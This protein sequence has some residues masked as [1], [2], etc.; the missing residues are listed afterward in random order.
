MN[1]ALKIAKVIIL[2]LLALIALSTEM[3]GQSYELKLEQRRR[4]N[5]IHVE[6][7]ARS[8]N[9]NAPKMGY[10]SLI[11]QYNTSFLKPAEV[12]QPSFTDTVNANINQLNPIDSIGSQFNTTNGYQSLNTR[13]YGDG[14]Y[15]LEVTLSQ[16]GNQGLAP[17]GSG[18]GS[19]IGKV[20]FDIIDNPTA[21]DLT[22]IEWSKS[23]LPGN[24]QLFD[25]DSTNIKSSAIWTDPG[26]FTVTGVTVLSP[27]QFGQVV[28]RDENY[29]VLTGAY[30]QGGYPIYFERSIS[31]ALYQ[32]PVDEDLA[33][34]F[35]YSLDNGGN[36]TNIG[37]V[38]ETDRFASVVGNQPEY[39]FGEIYNPSA[40]NSFTITTQKGQRIDQNNYRAPLRAIWAKNPNFTFRSE[41]AIVKV[42]LISGAGEL[43]IW[44]ETS[45]EDV[46]NERLVLGRLF[47][48]QLNGEYEYLKTPTSY[49]NATQLTVEAWLN[50]NS[51]QPAGS[52]T[53]IVVSSAG[54]EATPYLGSR[55]GAWM[56]YLKD[57][58]YPAF[59]AREI[60]ARGE[61]GFIGTVVAYERDFLSVASD[62]EP[63]TN[64]HAENWVHIAA[65]VDDNKLKLYVNG[66]IV[67]EINNTR[68]TDIRMMT[69]NHPIWIG[70][71][72]NTR[73]EADDY[74]H[75]GIKGVKV[76]RTALNQDEIRRNA[77][78]VV[79][80]T[81]I[82]G[83]ADI[84]KGLQ[85]YYTFEGSSFDNASDTQYQYGPELLDYYRN[86]LVSSLPL[87][88]R[89]DMPHIKITSPTE[90]V[91]VLNKPND[92]FPIRWIAY[93]IG[94]IAA[95]NTNDVTI[96]YSIDNGATWVIARNQD[97]Q[98]LGT[99]VPVDVELNRAS[100]EAY[101]NNDAL[102]NIRTINP[103]YRKA[104]L[105]VR[106]NDEYTQSSLNDTEG[107]FYI[108][109]YFSLKKTEGSILTVPATNSMNL[110]NNDALI[111]A[112]IRPYRFPSDEERY[113]PIIEKADSISN[114]THYSLR[115]LND[116]ALEF[117][118]TDASGNILS[119]FSDKNAP[120]IKPNSIE[121]DTAWTHVAVQLSKNST[122][123]SDVLFYIDGTPQT[124]DSLRNQFGSNLSINA[125]N[126]HPLYIGYK[127]TL[128][129]SD[130][131]TI[132]LEAI[133]T[134]TLILGGNINSG[135]PAG[136]TREAA[137][138]IYDNAGNDYELNAIFTKTDINNEYR[139][140]AEIDGNDIPTQTENIR[141]TGNIN[142]ADAIGSSY[143]TQTVVR[144]YN[145]E[146]HLL[147]LVFTKTATNTYNLEAFIGE[148]A[149]SQNVITFLSGG[150][151]LEPVTAIISAADLNSVVG[152]N[153]FDEN[154][155]KDINISLINLTNN[156]NES[157]AI[158]DAW[159]YFVRFNNDGT[160]A[161][162]Y[163]IRLNALD[164]N[165]ALGNL[166]FDEATPKNITV[167]IAEVG[168]E[169]NGVSQTAANDTYS[170]ISQDGRTSSTTLEFTEAPKGFIGEIREVRFWNGL[171]NNVSKGGAE[172]TE[173]TK[174]IQG[175]MNIY[176]ANLTPSFNANL[177]GA[178]SFNGGSFVRNGYHRAAA[179]S[180]NSAVLIKYFGDKVEYL[181]SE[182]YIK[183][184]E[185]TFRQ[186]VANS[187]ENLKVRWAGFNFN[188]LGFTPG[189]GNISPSLE[190]SIRGG[191]GNVIQ[192]YQYL[193]SQFWPGNSTNS[194][195]LPDSNL[196]RYKGT[197]S[198]VI[199][200]ARVNAG[201][202]DPDEN[203]DGTYND[204]GP[205]S[206]SLTNS[207]LRLTYNY[208]INSESKSNKAEG[209]LFTVT[210]ASNFTVRV[211]LEGYHNGNIL[212]SEM[213]NLGTSF[214]EGGLRISLYEDNSGTLGKLVGV[215]ESSQ[216]YD[217]RNPINRNRGN[218]RFANVNFIFTELND[219]D[220]WVLVEHPNHLPIMSRFAAP[221]IYEGDDR[222]TWP[223]ES[224]WDFQTWN[225]VSN[226]VL[227]A[228][229][230]NPYDSQSFTAFGDAVSLVSSPDFSTTGLIYNDGQQGTSTAPIAAM[231]GGDVDGSLQID[232]AD[233][234][235]VRLDDG[236]S[237]VRSDI[238]GDK[239]VNADD[240]TIT[241]RNFGHV[242]ST[243]N[244]NF[245]EEI[246]AERK[247]PLEIISELDPDLS[248]VFVNNAKIKSNKNIKYS[249]EKF[250]SQGIIYQ[251]NAQ[252]EL[253]GNF[254]NVH[255]YI[256]NLGTK[257]AL[258]N[259]TFAIKYDPSVLGFS[260]LIGADS[261]I[262]SDKPEKGY[263]NLRTAPRDDSD[264]RFNDVRS[265]E[266][267]YDAYANPGGE[268][269][270]YE[271]TFIGTLRFGIKD[272]NN[273]ISFDWHYSTSVH[274]TDG[275][276]VT[277]KGNFGV[278]P[279][280][281]LY[282]VDLIYP[283]G[284]ESFSPNSIANI[285]WTSNATN[286]DMK[287]QFSS[288]GG[289]TWYPVNEQQVLMAA[290]E[291]AWTVPNE[292]STR[293]LI[294]V[295]DAADNEELDRSRD[296]FSIL[297][298]FAQ[299]IRP[300]SADPLYSGGALAEITWFTQG[301]DKIYFEFSSDCG[302]SW[303]KITNTVNAEDRTT[304]WKIPVVTSK[305]AYIR[306]MDNNTGIEIA[307]SGQFRILAGT[308]TFSTP[309]QGEILYVDSP[310]R[311][312]WATK[313]VKEF[314]LDISFD[315]G[316]S[317]EKLAVNLDARSQG[318]LN[319]NVTN[320]PTENAIIRATWQGD[321]DMEY[322]R[323][324]TF[325]I[326][327][328]TSVNEIEIDNLNI[329]P[330]PATEF[331]NIS[332]G[333]II[334]NIEIIAIDG[335]VLFNSYN[336]NTLDAKIDARQ[337]PS[338]SYIMKI[339]TQ[340]G[341]KSIEV[342]VAR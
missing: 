321:P 325:R 334:K 182:P 8:L 329:F 66:E 298:S 313:N 147:D 54:S 124:A 74:L 95:T 175:A 293:C 44:Q 239:V 148:D 214:D 223:I 142:S 80:P 117:R 97:G 131:D 114:G 56:L 71:N 234:V 238:T 285:K 232:A 331:F 160:I 255:F 165:F 215:S 158:A 196:F 282:D 60:Q 295:L 318:Y 59:R 52:E 283:D 241:D 278:I 268:L 109:P 57:G 139:F 229:E 62:A 118:I 288:N 149:V 264:Q 309:K 43:D 127:P 190:F 291:Y 28:D 154:S 204:Q 100:W 336:I 50:L 125:I 230:N 77:S 181:P 327:L 326:V 323:T 188:G 272:K 279:S 129:K 47:F 169:A 189:Q 270:P 86:G 31:P 84:K 133:Q 262:F 155:P 220:Y 123:Q 206:A 265:I 292:N 185:P 99:E 70:V 94:D 164:I 167:V 105:R 263:V 92:L 108:A 30:A 197:G 324:G 140:T 93:G 146:D 299:I 289:N 210:P 132:N 337:L 273:K 269:V 144:D 138:T 205:L 46:S 110:S 23:S 314:D 65:T 235:Q 102:A 231:I 305:C 112:W 90:G 217:N 116:G 316:F 178:F 73:I 20:I 212:N 34:D 280:I 16:L 242:A 249:T 179:S 339:F 290:G 171:P 302:N 41:Q 224:G 83:A 78:G 225:G 35:E 202:A 24:I 3:F 281:R 257:F 186:Q 201:I 172:P 150:A 193:G 209:P 317:W 10:A 137:T 170:I 76:W 315:G 261:V 173:L 275:F 198:D 248:E 311:I 119:A 328:R 180:N 101:E 130:P 15:S 322:A 143:T 29:T 286:R 250:Q 251:V 195:S 216:A 187:D 135:T 176:S 88:F 296:F 17:S 166:A 68:A 53:G 45:L 341:F 335:T 203:N 40:A 259:C 244:V 199:F 236:T 266:V 26:D 156:S 253:E 6:V 113:F 128:V 219:G 7:W 310:T 301:Y 330:N 340:N 21:D 218:N 33:Y 177:F 49:S 222:T 332:A 192:P 312:R 338:G 98:R 145:G 254:V 168:N 211:L 267:D 69:S 245:P 319:W 276:I 300:S 85:L 103:Y 2:M 157:N 32:A 308:F 221:F 51:Y 247:S 141:I 200:A 191:G 243:F 96:E 194:I 260:G 37:R 11:M 42:K 240:R 4:F 5:Q 162:P 342:K 207:R 13:S 208:T 136:A 163:T 61:N 297:P 9:T 48:L 226:N 152:E 87:T 213:R 14:F 58:R 307:R 159:D 39:I 121:L 246:I 111:E 115:L 122:T 126:N 284:G 89:P 82:S 81:T 151:I 75:A 104:I 252:T 1:F 38:R 256:K 233:R 228:A 183:L 19:F 91:G 333:E 304:S 12:Q 303:S 64:L 79:N 55:E 320:N 306:M 227:M 36:W 18:R 72:P 120:L 237:L 63:L 107:E 106:G 161:T 67:D 174:W 274:T 22:L 258:A 287:I 134:Q 27:N 25:S 153:S 271:D 277:E 184:I 294:R